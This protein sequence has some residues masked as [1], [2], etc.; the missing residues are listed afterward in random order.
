MLQGV[1]PDYTC[2]Q[3]YTVKMEPG[4]RLRACAAEIWAWRGTVVANV[5]GGCETHVA[6]G[7]GWVF[8]NMAELRR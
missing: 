6:L 7:Q 3:T 1:P 4:K 2:V 8:Y 5:V